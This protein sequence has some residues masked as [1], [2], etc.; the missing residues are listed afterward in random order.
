[1]CVC[2]TSG[3]SYASLWKGVMMLYSGKYG[4]LEKIGE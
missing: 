4:Q 3:S 1:M 2:F